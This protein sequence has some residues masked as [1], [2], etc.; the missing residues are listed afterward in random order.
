MNTLQHASKSAIPITVGHAVCRA[1]KGGCTVDGRVFK[2]G[3]FC[4]P[5]D[6]IDPH[7]VEALVET[8]AARVAIHGFTYTVREIP[9]GEC[10]TVAFEMHRTDT[11]HTYHV[12]RNHY[13][14][15]TCDCPDY[16]FRHEGSAGMCKHGSR[17]VELGMIATPTPIRS[18]LGV[19]EF[20]GNVSVLR[21]ATPTRTEYP[22]RKPYRFEPSPAERAEASQLFADLA[23]CR[24]FK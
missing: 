19:R 4:L 17:L 14:L 1:P 16:L 8:K 20:Y 3:Q 7:G 2:G 6:P 22:V 12:V 15:V 10:G 24:H 9:A 13:G 11:N 18:T 23:C 5:F 21:N